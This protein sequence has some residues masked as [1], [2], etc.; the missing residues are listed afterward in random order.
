M[1]AA[2]VRPLFYRDG[3]ERAPT[4]ATFYLSDSCDND[5]F[6]DEIRM[7]REDGR[8]RLYYR[9]D[10]IPDELAQSAHSTGRLYGAIGLA[11]GVA[12]GWIAVSGLFG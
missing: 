3:A 5:G 9:K 6:P 4:G 1:K 8:T 12:V 11:I 10:S 7:H 2:N